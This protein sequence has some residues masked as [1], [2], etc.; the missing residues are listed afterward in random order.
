[1]LFHWTWIHSVL[2]STWY[3]TTVV[4]WTRSL[5][6]S[7]IFKYLIS[8]WWPHLSKF[9]RCGLAEGNMSPGMGFDVRRNMISCRVVLCFLYRVWDVSTHLS[10]LLYLM[11]PCW[12]NDGLLSL[13]N[14][15]PSF[16]EL[17]WSW[18]FV[19]AI[20]K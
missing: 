17:S 1:M 16:H 15:Q 9:L 19:T 11:L 3:F 18:Y 20:V 4:I 6:Y 7:W 10:L 8:Y 14:Y 2:P 5:P 12:H 13:W